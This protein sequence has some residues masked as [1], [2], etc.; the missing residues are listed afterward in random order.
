MRLVKL[1]HNNINLIKNHLRGNV[2]NTFFVS[3]VFFFDLAWGAVSM[4]T[5]RITIF[6][7]SPSFRN[8]VSEN[9]DSRCFTGARNVYRAGI[10]AD[11][12]GSV[13]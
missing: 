8:P 1:F 5:Y 10:G 2:I 7:Y 13:L 4:N 6:T 3:T 9:V 11:C 12:Y